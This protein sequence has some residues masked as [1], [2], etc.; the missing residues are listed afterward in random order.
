L[1]ATFRR[2]A[3]N[4]L[5]MSWDSADTLKLLVALLLAGL[6]WFHDKLE[7]LR[8]AAKS[9]AEA[10]KEAEEKC[11]VAAQVRR[12]AAE[13]QEEYMNI[14]E[15]TRHE[16]RKLAE[17]RIQRE[18]LPLLPGDIEAAVVTMYKRKI[19][20]RSHPGAPS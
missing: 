17:E 11:R 2:A 4:S 14:E 15:G 6:Y 12:K 18:C 8:A 19:Y 7:A 20:K 5:T 16:L 3:Y 1:R 13:I 10:R 9:E